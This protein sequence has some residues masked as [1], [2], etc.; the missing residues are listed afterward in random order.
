MTK[1][2]MSGIGIAIGALALWAAP[3]VADSGWAVRIC[4]GATEA[5]EIEIEVGKP[6]GEDQDLVDWKSD[7]TATDFPVP[8]PFKDEKQIHVDADSDPDDGKVAMCVLYNGV[9]VKAMNF[10]DELAVTA[11][12][13]DKDD[14]CKCPKG[15]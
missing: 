11:S 15:Q 4:R 3:A 13:T 7:N 8:A 14:G 5:S 6:G 12:Q 2:G 10:N 9:P 1:R